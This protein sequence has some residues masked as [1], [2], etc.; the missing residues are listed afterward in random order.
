MTNCSSARRAIPYLL[1]ALL[2]VAGCEAPDEISDQPIHAAYTLLAQSDTGVPIA[3]AR[4]IVD[5]VSAS[6]PSLT[7]GAQLISMSARVNPDTAM[8][9]ITVCEAVIPFVQS[10]IVSGAEDTLA[11]VTTNP[12]RL[13]IYGDTGCK[14]KE[15]P[16]S[17]AAHPFDS[18]A[19]AG[20]RRD[21]LPDLLLH[22]GDYNYRGTG[23][24]VFDGNT[25]SVY[26]AGDDASA[27][28][29]CQLNSL[30]YS[31][32]AKGSTQHDNW[33]NWWLDFFLPAQPLLPKAPW[34]FARGNHELCSRAGPGWFYF[35]DTGSNLAVAATPQASCPPQGDLAHPD[36][37]KMSDLQFVA[38]YAVNLDS[39][40]ILVLDSAN[41]CDAFAPDPT[42]K[43]YTT[44]FDTLQT[45][46]ADETTTWVMTHR[47]LWGV[48]KE[49]ETSGDTTFSII[50]QTLQTALRQT[51]RG[52][53]PSAVTLSLC[54]HM[55]RYES[56]TFSDGR[57]PQVVI[58]NSGVKLDT[59]PPIGDFHT[60]VDSLTAQ[61]NATDQFGFLDMAFH[62]DG[63][64]RGYLVF[65]PDTIATCDSEH[66]KQGR[67]LCA[68]K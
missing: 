17:V 59:K 36:T 22:M 25:L 66:V 39:L 46:T 13:F 6:C 8:F 1:L 60:T 45:L 42:T 32:N 49:S 38:P 5:G 7:G 21:T 16:G 11:A 14:E 53:L 65:P 64:W 58:G 15:C 52:A 34:I 62:P 48:K 19:H 51:R 41:A 23:H 2:L 43:R 33:D 55:H 47:P 4:V 44:Q 29:L 35:L 61:G 20:A 68:L 18:L 9:P 24:L 67:T 50:N 28:S 26:D 63:S 37:L 56:L 54:G 30:Y 10:L 57:P 12:S 31:Q 27:D 40:R 3:Y